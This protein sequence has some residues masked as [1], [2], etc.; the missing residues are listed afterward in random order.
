MADGEEAAADIHTADAEL[1]VAETRSTT[2]SDINKAMK[3]HLQV[4]LLAAALERA[5]HL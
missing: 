5:P 1:I 2:F 4:L 3:V